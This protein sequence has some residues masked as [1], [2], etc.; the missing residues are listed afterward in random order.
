MA[1]HDAAKDGALVTD[2]TERHT[3]ECVFGPVG[4]VAQP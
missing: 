4:E 2:C 1:D 3:R